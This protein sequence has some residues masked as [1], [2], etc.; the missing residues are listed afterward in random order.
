[1]DLYATLAGLAG[2]EVPGALDSRPL[3]PFIGPTP[4]PARENIFAM[5]KDCQRSIRDRRWKL[6]RYHVQGS[7]RL[8]LFDL[9]KD[10]NELND[11]SAVSGNEETIQR[12]LDLL[13]EWQHR[14]GDRWMPDL[15]SRLHSRSVN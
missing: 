6:I 5:Y 2:I 7:D 13:R 14:V 10:P 4:T 15:D 11:L 8:Q 3:F 1:M 12:L 9:E